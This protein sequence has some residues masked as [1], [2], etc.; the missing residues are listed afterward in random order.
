M[1]NDT[2][3]EESALEGNFPGRRQSLLEAAGKT[4]RCAVP[5]ARKPWVAI[6]GHPRDA[7]VAPVF[8]TPRKIPFQS[9]R[10][11]IKQLPFM[12]KPG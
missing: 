6:H 5:A 1:N 7:C 10:R 11:R 12:N 8:F 9:R 4:L 3:H 2:Y